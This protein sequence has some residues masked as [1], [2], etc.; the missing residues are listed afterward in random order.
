MARKRGISFFVSNYLLIFLWI[1]TGGSVLFIFQR[2]IILSLLFVYTILLIVFGRG[3]M[4]KVHIGGFIFA[5]LI[6]FGS[7]LF[8]YN[9]SIQPQ[10]PIKY[11]YDALE[12]FVVGFV[13]IY[14]FS[15]FT[16]E[17]FQLMLFKV[18]RFIRWHAL[19]NAFLISFLPKLLS[20]TIVYTFT[21][22]TANTF[23]MMFFSEPA[24]YSFNIAGLS[25]TRNQGLF[26]E[27]GVLQFYL[28]LLL[29][30]QLYVY[31][32][33]NMPILLTVGAI[34]STYSSSAYLIML[35]ISS[36]ALIRSIKRQPGIYFP[37]SIVIL[38]LFI[39]FLIGNIENKFQ[40]AQQTSSVL[41]ML[42][43]V[44]QMEVIKGNALTGVGL[45]DE[46]YKTIRAK[47]QVT[48]YFTDAQENDN[49]VDRAGTNSITF[50]VAAVGVP[51]GF[52]W[53]FAY[54]EQPFFR[55]R[56]FLISFLLFGTAFVEPVLLKPF[57]VTFIVSGFMLIY[58][59]L[60][61]PGGKSIWVQSKVILK[62][63]S[64]PE[65]AAENPV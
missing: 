51:I 19:V 12:F 30:F 32:S 20:L 36:A 60:R 6:G 17:G 38:G 42:D 46:A 3:R 5:M 22:Y 39:P 63:P 7:I 27:P 35:V 31:K 47:Y 14:L 34:I 48:G 59:K 52:L 54:F 10:D 65:V 1:L 25:L 44:Q 9:F 61:H 40:G 11:V 15:V 2:N 45:D 50:L 8:D 37:L 49:S 64:A 43:F 4:K 33:K 23:M 55:K 57:F 41:R 62:L 58:Y 24:Q 29:Y 21:N 16:Y 26:W 53:L 18:L 13:C 28:N 56:R